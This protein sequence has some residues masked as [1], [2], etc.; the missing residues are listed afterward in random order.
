MDTNTFLRD[1]WILIKFILVITLLFGVPMYL[2]NLYQ[3][4]HPD[5]SPPPHTSVMVWYTNGD[6][7]V[8]DIPAYPSKIHIY[9]NRGSSELYYFPKGNDF[10]TNTAASGVRRFEII[11][12]NY[13]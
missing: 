5:L 1:L 4:K 12:S 2:G 6:S 9:D 8:I 13:K 7:E 3:E 10:I 11:K